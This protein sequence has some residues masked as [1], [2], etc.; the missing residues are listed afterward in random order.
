MSHFH[1]TYFNRRFN[2][3]L[4]SPLPRIALN[5]GRVMSPFERKRL[6]IFFNSSG[7]IRATGVSGRHSRSERGRPNEV[8]MNRPDIEMK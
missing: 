1:Q 3:P 4:P 5:E 7:G 2:L 6:T 8:G